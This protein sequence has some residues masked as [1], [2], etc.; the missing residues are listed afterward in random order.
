MLIGRG[1]SELGAIVIKR[2]IKYLRNL[3]SLTISSLRLVRMTATT[4]G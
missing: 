1:M 4:I 2:A 3:T